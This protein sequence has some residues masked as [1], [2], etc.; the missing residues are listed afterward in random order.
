MIGAT[1]S[2]EVTAT[3]TDASAASTTF[4]IAIAD[5]DEFDVAIPKDIDAAANTVAENAPAGTMVGITARALDRDATNNAVTYRLGNN[6][7]GRFAIDPT[8][9]I[10]A[11]AAA[12]LLDFEA[13]ASHSISVEAVSSDGSVSSQ[14][15]A[16]SVTN[17]NEPAIIAGDRTGSVTEDVTLSAAGRLTVDP[18][19]GQST[20]Q[21]GT[22]AGTYGSLT[23]GADGAWTY[24]LNNANAAVQ[25][26]NSGQSLTDAIAVR[27]QDDTAA[28]VVITINGTDDQNVITGTNAANVLRGTGAADIIT[29]LGGP[30]AVFAGGGDDMIRSTPNDGADLYD[31]GSGRDTVDYSALTRSI[32]AVL[33]DLAGGTGVT[34]GARSGT[35]AL[36]SIE[37]VI[38]SQARDRIFGNGAANVIVGG[39][40][41]DQLRA[42]VATT[43]W[44]VAWATT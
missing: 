3:S 24:A 18:D 16:I 1:A 4:A 11:V 10:V 23:L 12:A 7:G 29:A 38:G 27:S 15:F 19:A 20:F 21:A 26:L 8:S 33:S 9:G 22:I 43:D 39:G 25:A 32:E 14:E 44:R 35:D 34:T 13:A 30:D 5:V 42:A 28:S 36:V 41:N 31:G 37:N 2:V 17:V 6:A 40:G